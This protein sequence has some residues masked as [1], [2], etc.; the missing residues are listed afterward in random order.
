[1]RRG[2]LSVKSFYIKMELLLYIYQYIY[3]YNLERGIAQRCVGFKGLM[4]LLEG[5]QFALMLQIRWFK[6]SLPRLSSFASAL[7]GCPGILL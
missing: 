7:G 3:I 1:M 6:Q 2:N 5:L 4:I